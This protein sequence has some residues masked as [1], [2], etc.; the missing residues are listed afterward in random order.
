M[1][2]RTGGADRGARRL[3]RSWSESR[4]QLDSFRG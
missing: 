3:S 2:D 1:A 4:S